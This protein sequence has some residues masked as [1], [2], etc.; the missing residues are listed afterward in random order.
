MNARLHTESLT[1]EDTVLDYAADNHDD[2][3][4][5]LQREQS[6]YS[7]EHSVMAHFKQHL[8]HSMTAIFQSTLGHKVQFRDF[9][10]AKKVS[11]NKVPNIALMTFDRLLVI[12]DKVKTLWKHN[13]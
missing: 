4:F 13:L 5:Y 3:P 8:G 1:F 9:K 10:A 11:L 2:S 6:Y 7:N 12:I